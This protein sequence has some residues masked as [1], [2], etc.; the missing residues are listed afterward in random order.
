MPVKRAQIDRAPLLAAHSMDD[1]YAPAGHSL[2]L[3]S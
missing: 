3:I 2:I 1:V